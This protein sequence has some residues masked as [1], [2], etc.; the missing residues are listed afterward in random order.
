MKTL[1]DGARGW[2]KAGLRFALIVL[3]LG[4]FVVFT[5]SMPGKSYSGALGP[6]SQ[7]ERQLS[8]NLKDHVQMLAGT[9]G[10]RNDIRYKSLQDAAQYLESSLRGNGYQVNSQEYLAE[11][12]TVRN[13][14]TELP[15][16]AVRSEIVVV[17]AHY[18][19]AYDCPAA[20]DNTSG[21]AAL[22]ELARLL[23]P[24]HPART[25]R[26]VAFVNE[27]PPYFQTAN[28]GSWVYAKKAHAARENIVAAIS[29][30]TIGMYMETPGSQ[31]YP[32]GFGLLYPS[33]GDFIAFVGNVGSR[34]LVRDTLRSFRRGTA[35]PSQGS[36]VPGWIAGVGWSDHWSFWQEGY[37]A[38]MVTDTAL[39]RNPNYHQPSDKPDTLDYDRMARV[40]RGLATVIMDLG[41]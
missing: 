19:T 3:A 8:A 37:P 39:F 21:T 15:G 7:E 38:V 26:F 30:E 35:F 10:E 6:L 2:R 5:T 36:A 14:A 1:P 28:M 34:G 4:L 12:K 40:V 32:A 18:D 41:K 11:G 20:D 31:H 17:G 24:S 29:L 13:L 16:A 22:L 23:K 9:I 33:Q 27:E 25:V